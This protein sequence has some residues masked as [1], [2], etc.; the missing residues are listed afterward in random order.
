M[1]Y[2]KE[3]LTLHESLRGK[4]SIQAKMD[5]DSRDGLSLLYSPGVAEPCK[6]I[7]ANP[8]DVWKYTIKS[9][10]VAVVTDGTA[11]LGLGNIGALAALP[12][13]EGK[14]MLF[15]KFGDVD[16]FPICLDTQDTEEVIET[17]RRIAPVF[18]GINL[19]DISAPVAL[20][21]KTAFK[22]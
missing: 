16:A 5:I 7:H 2:F 14:A 8:S 3:S 22:I 6:R 18:G 4:I 19:E 9:N 11:V 17:I 13:M 15:K 1:D 20:K 12:V 21:S 10:M